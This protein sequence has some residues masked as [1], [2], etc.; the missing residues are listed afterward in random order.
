MVCRR[1]ATNGMTGRSPGTTRAAVSEDIQTNKPFDDV[2]FCFGKQRT[3]YGLDE[4]RRGTSRE[5]GTVNDKGYTRAIHG[6]ETY[7]EISPVSRE[8]RTREIF[9]SSCGHANGENGR[10]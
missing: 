7:E 2:L 8:T 10:H 4:T 5:Y 1:M 9:V 6:Q 3:A